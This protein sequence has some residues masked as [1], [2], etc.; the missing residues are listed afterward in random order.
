M[1]HFREGIAPLRH[2]YINPNEKSNK[3]K[4]SLLSWLTKALTE[5]LLQGNVPL[6]HLLNA[7]APYVI[8]KEN[9]MQFIFSSW[10][11]FT[12]ILG[13][14]HVESDMQTNVQK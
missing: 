10:Y 5:H 4:S 3:Y 8:Y 14:F 7:K 12:F 1:E 9:I 2:S 6:R 13:S 11:Y